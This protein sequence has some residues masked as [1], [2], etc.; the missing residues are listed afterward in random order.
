V[1][2]GHTA[3]VL[4]VRFVNRGMQ[5]IS[6]ASDGLVRLWTIRT[7]ECENT[8]DEH[9]DRVWALATATVPGADGHEEEVRCSA[10]QCNARHGWWGR[11]RGRG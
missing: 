4:T 3:S 7:G 9:A 11:G 2:A 10:M 1:R 6:G 5:L 8:F